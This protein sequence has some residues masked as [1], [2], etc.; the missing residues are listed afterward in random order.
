MAGTGQPFQRQVNRDIKLQLDSSFSRCPSVLFCN[1]SRE[2]SAWGAPA[3]EKTLQRGDQR[4]VWFKLLLTDRCGE[5][6]DIAPA[7]LQQLAPQVANKTGSQVVTAFLEFL[8]SHLDGQLKLTFGTDVLSRVEVRTTMTVPAFWND[9]E[10][11][12]L[13]LAAVNAGFEEM[14][15]GFV[16]EPEAAALACVAQNYVHFETG[17][18]FLVTDAGGGTVDLIAYKVLKDKPLSLKEAI[19]G[20]GELCGSTDLNQGFEKFLRNRLKRHV[21][22]LSETSIACLIKEFNSIIK[23]RFGETDDENEVYKISLPGYDVDDTEAG[24]ADGV[25]TISRADLKIVF[26]PVVTKIVV[27]V[28]TQIVSI[29]RTAQ[30]EVKVR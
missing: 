12:I 6:Y 17:D 27:L 3:L 18:V 22:L 28:S 14:R 5:Y 10:R 24:I 26:Q 13:R 30:K 7:E 15:L 1:S 23:V 2:I 25:L 11:N 4:L 9:K 29:V 19:A 8:K 16:T 20:I 21:K